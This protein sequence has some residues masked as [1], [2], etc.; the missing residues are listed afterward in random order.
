M[1]GNLFL[2]VAAAAEAMSYR[3][4]WNLIHNAERHLGSSLIASQPGGR[5]GGGTHLSDEGRQ[6][7]QV[8]RKLKEEV[9]RFARQRLVEIMDELGVRSTD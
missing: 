2:E 6:L 5:G 3:H 1:S 4:A 9:D 7:L 8:H